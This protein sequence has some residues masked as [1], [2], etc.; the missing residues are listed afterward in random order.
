ML[1]LS[2]IS[3]CK[4]SKILNFNTKFISRICAYI[5]RITWKIRTNYKTLDF[6]FIHF[7]HIIFL[8]NE[9]TLY[10]EYERY[11]I[12]SHRSINALSFFSIFV[13]ILL[14]S[15]TRL[16]SFSFRINRLFVKFDKFIVVGFVFCTETIQT[17]K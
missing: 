12:E 4:I 16:L 14:S 7:I 11:Q 1:K 5:K 2:S 9:I 8:Y 17:F 13:F 3:N 6:L 10:F 15:P